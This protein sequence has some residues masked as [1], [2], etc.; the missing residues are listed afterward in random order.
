VFFAYHV[1]WPSGWSGGFEW[2]LLVIGVSA[3]IALF[4]FR[5][6]V[7]P[8]ILA[9]GAAGLLFQSFARPLLG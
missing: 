2:P 9:C 3:G 4:R 8:T 5:A 7:I 6:G 1:L